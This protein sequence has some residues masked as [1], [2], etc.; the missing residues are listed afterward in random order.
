M[1][2][3]L[4]LEGKTAVVTGAGGAIGSSIAKALGKQGVQVSI[5][6]IS[7]EKGAETS[8]YINSTEGKAIAV[9]CD[10][11]KP[12]DVNNATKETLSRLGSIDILINAAGGSLKDATTSEDLPFFDISLEAMQKGFALNYFSTLLTCQ[13]VGQIFA[14]KGK[15][16][17]LNISSIAGVQPLSR[18]ISYSDAKAA[19]NSFTRWLSVHMAEQYSPNIRVNA[20]A[21]GF[22]L[23]EQNRFLLIDEKSGKFTDR[24][25]T[26]VNIVP[27]ARLG[28]PNEID[29]ATLWI[30]SEQASFITGAVIPIDGGFTASS[31]V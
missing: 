14:D 15:G 30:V 16:V 2:L 22:I 11:T 4:G 28:K 6:D 10:V 19:V 29:G 8:E 24:G 23:T 17:I 27:M 9:T 12:K 13:T 26:I 31:G 5:W 21:P 25:R 20:I 7:S 1:S 3:K 18:A